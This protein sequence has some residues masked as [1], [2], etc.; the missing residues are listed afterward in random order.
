MIILF[1]FRKRATAGVKEMRR[2]KREK[3]IIN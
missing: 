1:I 3:N 2:K